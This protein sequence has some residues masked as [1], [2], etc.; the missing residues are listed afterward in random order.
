MHVACASFTFASAAPVTAVAAALFFVTEVAAR[1][2]K[3]S[4]EISREFNRFV[5][6]RQPASRAP[7]TAIAHDT[8]NTEARHVA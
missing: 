2:R 7:S 4:R 5:P 6:R 8:T 3:T 1:S